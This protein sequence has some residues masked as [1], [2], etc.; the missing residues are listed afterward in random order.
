MAERLKDVIGFGWIRIKEKDNACV[1][2][3]HTI[4]GVI[5]VVSLMNSYLRTPKLCK[6]NKLIHFINV[7]K[8]LNLIKY[9]VNTEDFN[10][11]SWFA[12]FVDADG[13]FGIINDYKALNFNGKVIRKRK[14]SCRL[15]IEQRMFDPITKESY[16]SVFKKIA[17]FL[18]VNLNVVKRNNGKEYFN[19]TAKSRKSITISKNY[20]SKYSLFSSK[21]LDYKN[22]EKVVELIIKQ[23][24][25][26]ETNLVLIDELK[27]D[28]N[29]SRKSFNWSHL[30]ILGK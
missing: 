24:H 27:K 25:Y 28:M 15:R 7:K 26:E 17:A 14:V 5:F 3:F 8:N 10:S 2:V 23:T 13:S 29:H 9:P 30:D 16:Q 12:G 1:L 4:D 22:W 19:I 18:D 11:D 21:Y 20:F 6:F